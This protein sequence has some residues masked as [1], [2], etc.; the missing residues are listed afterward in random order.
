MTNEEKLAYNERKALQYGWTPQ[1]F[2]CTRFDVHLLAAIRSFQ[3]QH[4]LSPDGM[5]GSST[6]RRLWTER[7]QE[8]DYH[9][10]EH[11]SS[12][13]QKHIIYNGNPIPI[14]WDKVVLWNEEGGMGASSGHYS[15]YAG[16]PPRKPSFFVTHWDVCLSSK[17]CYRVLEQRG[18]SVH[19]GIDNDGTIYQWL[20][21]QHAAWHA[22]GRSWNHSSIG[23]EVSNAYDTKYQSWYV[24]HGLG[25]RP[26]VSN[27]QIHGRRLS[28]FLGFYDV[29]IR[30]L[31]ALWR[32]ISDGVGIPLELPATKD[33]VDPSAAKNEFQGF[34]N[35]YHLTSR[36]ID[37]A[38]LD[39][40]LVLA[41]AK[42]LRTPL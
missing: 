24:K 37:C 14:V 26:V 25:E 40:K 27:A 28:P 5:C 31:A 17:S 1:W 20:D 16:Q 41:R 23:V 35:H 19:F 38:G 8:G 33:R 34:C 3:A 18:I 30:A 22:G 12:N 10:I 7:Q 32:A 9:A 29:Q 36:K 4:G 2:G 15:D 42:Q 13:T 6:F 11:D 21:C 39:N